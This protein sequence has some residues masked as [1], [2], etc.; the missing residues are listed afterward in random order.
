MPVKRALVFGAGGFIGHHLVTR[1]RSE[2]LWVRGVDLKLPE[3]SETSANDF[4]VGDLRDPRIVDDA[5]DMQFDEVFQLAADMGGA[6]YIFTGENDADVMHNSASIN[7]NI[8]DSCRHRKVG[9][10]FYP[11]FPIWLH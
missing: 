10:I 8:L 4:V 5:I 1:L 7:L 2:G 9:R 6:G 3:Y 11:G